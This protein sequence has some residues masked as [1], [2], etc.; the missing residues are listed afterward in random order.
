[1]WNI[2]LR[3]TLALL[4]KQLIQNC[5]LCHHL[6]TLMSLQILYDFF[7]FC[8]AQKDTFLVD[9]LDKWRLG[10][11]KMSK[12]ISQVFCSLMMA[13]VWQ[14]D[15][16]VDI[17]RKPYPPMRSSIS[18]QR[19]AFIWKTVA[20]LFKNF[21]FVFY[22]RKTAIQVLYCSNRTVSE[23]WQKQVIIVEK[24]NMKPHK[25]H[26]VAQE[27]LILATHLFSRCTGFFLV[28]LPPV[29][30]T[31]MLHKGGKPTGRGQR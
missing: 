20:I 19:I 4:S 23:W 2:T 15:R 29:D 5:K 12:Y 28:P 1:M 14:K 21:P 31:L 3:F 24:H 22:G 8:R 17:H 27:K 13:L 9:I 7:F 26:S 18:F 16:N 11:P 10:Y 6:V 30:G 25:K